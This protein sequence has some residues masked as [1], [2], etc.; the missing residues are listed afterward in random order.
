MLRLWIALLLL[1]VIALSLYTALAKAK[2]RQLR[3]AALGV[4]CAS[5]ILGG[6]WMIAAD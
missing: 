2:P 4:L 5:L 1:I 6:L 3:A